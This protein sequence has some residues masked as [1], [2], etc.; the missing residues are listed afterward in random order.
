MMPYTVRT[1]AERPDLI[2]EN[3]RLVDE[4]WA[5]F[6]KHDLVGDRY[7]GRL[8]EAFPGFQ[9]MLCDGETMVA[10]CNSIPVLWNLDDQL[11]SDAGWDWAIESG[12]GLL[13][14]GKTPTTLS[15]LSITIARSYLGRGISSHVLRVMKDLAAQHRFNAL[16]APVRPTLKARYP[17]IPME[18]YVT[19]RQSPDTD[20]PF[21]PWLRAHWRV[22]ARIVK[23]APRSMIIS[24]TFAE[25]EDWTGVKF[26]ES[27]E[28]IVE[29]ALNPVTAD[30]PNDRMTYV[31]P[32]VWMH[33]PIP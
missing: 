33:H 6:M 26:P 16:I 19:W 28:Y 21:D 4:G 12:F 7:F 20:A 29:G 30:R 10:T 3:W 25:W 31:E 23:V 22:G 2:D 8:Y 15:A 9:F 32:N 18:L 14:S 24:G 5:E 13:E 17:L 11:L 1:F 27:G